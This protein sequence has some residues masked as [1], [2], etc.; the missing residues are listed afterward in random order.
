[1]TMIEKTYPIAEKLLT[2]A[3]QLVEQLQRQLSH[4]ADALSQQQSADLINTIAATKKQ[5]VIQLEQFN[6]QLAQVLETEQL[7][8]TQGGIL[9]YLQRAEASGQ[10]TDD[11]RNNWAQIK[12]IAAACKALNEQNGAGIDLLAR[13]TQ[14]SL[15]I[16]KGKPQ[17]SHTYGP[18]GLSQSEFFS[19]S[20]ISV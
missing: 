3:V 15:H 11:S 10:H 19:H 2:G 4:E 12:A 9:S 6:K 18:N 8:N 20:L 7:P 17:M 14:R 5:L 1:M 16:L 13:H